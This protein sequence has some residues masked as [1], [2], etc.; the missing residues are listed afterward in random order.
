M[1]RHFFRVLSLVALSFLFV[2][3]EGTEEID[4]P[5]DVP[6]EYIGFPSDGLFVEVGKSVL[7]DVIVGPDN[8]T[9]KVLWSSANPSV[10][11]VDNS[12]RVTGVS[13]GETTIT[14]YAG[15]VSASC[16]VEVYIPYVPVTDISLSTTSLSMHVGDI[17]TVQASVL[18]ANATDKYVYWGSSNLEV[19]VIDRREGRLAAL[20][21]GKAEI[22]CEASGDKGVIKKSFELTVSAPEESSIALKYYSCQIFDDH[23]DITVFADNRLR[24]SEGYGVPYLMDNWKAFGTEIRYNVVAEDGFSYYDLV[25]TLS[26]NDAASF[27]TDSPDSKYGKYYWTFAFAN[28]YYNH[29]LASDLSNITDGEGCVHIVLEDIRGGK[30]VLSFTEKQGSTPKYYLYGNYVAVSSVSLDRKDLSLTVGQAETLHATVL[31]ENATN[32]KVSWRSSN[33][34]V[35]RVND[36]GEVSGIKRGTATI[37]AEVENKTASCEVTVVE[38]DVPV[39]SISLNKTSLS[40]S[41]GERFQLTATVLPE[42]A[43]I[44]SIEWSSSDT[45]VAAI[46]SDGLVTATGGGAATVTAKAGEKTATC[47]VNVTVPV[48]SVSLDKTTVTLKQNQGTML[49][50]TVYPPDATDKTVTWFSSNTS[51]ATVDDGKV[52]AVGLGKATVTAKA[53]NKSASCSITVEKDE[54]RVTGIS[55]ISHDTIE[56]DPYDVLDISSLY[57]IYP[58]NATNK[59]VNITSSNNSVVMV[60]GTQ[61]SAIAPGTAEITVITSDGG[62]KDSRSVKVR[63]DATVGNVIVYTEENGEIITFPSDAMSLFG[64]SITSHTMSGKTGTITFSSNIS[65]IGKKAF[66]EKYFLT[67]ITL[68]ETIVV[69]DEEAFRDCWYLQDFKVPSS[70]T[71]IGKDAFANCYKITGISLPSA[72]KTI[73]EGA[74]RGCAAMRSVSFGNQVTGIGN[75]AFADCNKLAD[76]T[77]PASVKS[78]GNNAFDNCNAF[79]RMTFESTV[80][81]SVTETSLTGSWDI[82]VPIGYSS[83]YKAKWPYYASRIKEETIPVTGISLSPASITLEQFDTYQLSATVLPENATNKGISWSTSSSFYVSVDENGMITAKYP[84]SATIK[85]T[86]SEG[87]Y[88]GTCIVTV[89]NKVYHVESV[90]L[91]EYELSLQVG[92]SAVLSATVLPENAS[93][94]KVKWSSGDESVASIDQNGNIVAKKIGTTKITVETEDGGFTD[95][96][97]VIVGACLV[98]G[99]SLDRQN[100]TLNKGDEIVLIAT[101]RPEN[102]TNKSVTWESDNS[103]VASVDGEGK[104]KA[105]S[106]GT[107][108]ITVTTE[109]GGHTASCYVTVNKTRVSAVYLDADKISLAIG[110]KKQ[111][112]AS[113]VPEDADD[114]SVTWSSSNSS[115]ASVDDD[116][117][118]TGL[119]KGTAT[120]TVKTVDGGYRASCE[121]TVTDKPVKG[122]SLDMTT[123]SL[124][125]G[126]SQRLTATVEP[127]DAGNK[128]VT[129]KSDNTSV[130]TVTREGLVTGVAP[131][132]TIITVKT[133]DGGFTATCTVTVQAIKVTGISLIPT[134]AT[135]YVGEGGEQL[136]ATVIPEDASDQTVTWKSSNT[137]VVTV[138]S[139]G[140]ANPV[141]PGYAV[142]TVT[143]KDGGYQAKCDIEVIQLVTSVTLDQH[144]L[145]LQY[146]SSPVQLNATALPAN[147]TDKT[148]LWESSDKSVATVSSSGLVTPKSGGKAVIYA[149]STVPYVL[150][151]CVVSV[152]G[153]KPSGG[154]DLGLS[155]YWS[156]RNLGASKPSDFGSFYA[157]G[158]TSAK[159]SYTD[160]NYKYMNS[161]F[162]V[163]KYGD[164]DGKTR[165]APSDDAAH[166]KL[167]GSWRMPTREEVQEL[168]DNCDMQHIYDYDGSFDASNPT[169]GGILVVS[170]VPGY[171]GN[172]IYLP[173]G[174][175]Y[176]NPTQ[177][178]PG[179]FYWTS[180]LGSYEQHAIGFS[181][182]SNTI[183]LQSTLVR[184]LGCMIR[185]V[186]P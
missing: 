93:N 130:A 50:A 162:E 150:D 168:I 116:G 20:K 99:V 69:I 125:P 61:L 59:D 174:P 35:A 132:S 105:V 135:L 23:T 33:E 141:S 182:T 68:P 111:L 47:S 26:V 118:V 131:G 36:D 161:D 1:T 76:L 24:E 51:V 30:Y 172:S 123:L 52:I 32:K 31:P 67:S 134:S 62:Y 43:S 11:S 14:A 133:E 13:A 155:V 126:G 167:G 53:G 40:L 143:T 72:V 136:N 34:G 87:G 25:E 41:K 110:E 119:E 49:T 149:K 122:V 184:F 186:C 112:T 115:I 92:A 9:D 38:Q 6:A 86:T 2:C 113:V 127:E 157:W 42:N 163:S 139:S 74:F 147:A 39:T 160:S 107:A 84:G 16:P 165:L 181:A 121:I 28:E 138:S 45:S 81:C 169:L 166:V 78:I 29:N 170:K 185:P 156:D 180:D 108:K 55:F 173:A 120:I 48:S 90:S 178:D 88:S 85:A 152:K 44:K 129:W 114:R 22:F 65:F 70:V 102:A 19:A 171:E 158:E 104:V 18:P 183:V 5:V 148:I 7:V 176:D 101:V 117:L 142:I 56:M 80:P 89:I 95:S 63:G 3:C 146:N 12:G 151:S 37:T 10:A 60:L 54:V 145:Q 21:E 27:K 94:K 71:A 8:T 106:A 66:A 175:L 164:N 77:I 91:S 82:Y 15:A 4:V 98:T 97:T 103:A 73:P 17:T 159:S 137:S 64:S 140:F 179:L 109:D 124:A 46:D 154:T 177:F 153:L 75:K 100:V 128:N 58:S 83:T 79:T 57:T 144:S 96:C